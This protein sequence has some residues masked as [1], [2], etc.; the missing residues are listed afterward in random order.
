[1]DNKENC[2]EQ[3]ISEQQQSVQ[4]LLYEIR[5]VIRKEL[6]NAEERIS[7]RM[8][9]YWEKHNIIH[10]AAFKNHIGLYPGPDAIIFFKDELQGLKTSKGAIQIPYEQPLP[11][12]LIA[13]ITKWCYQSGKHH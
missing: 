9:T 13:K 10:F 3:Y 2:I 5:E 12:A 11:L 4:P 1:M 6:P 7:W 8:P